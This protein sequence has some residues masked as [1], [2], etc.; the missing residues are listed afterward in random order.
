MNLFYY[1]VSVFGFVL[2][3]IFINYRYLEKGNIESCECDVV[4]FFLSFFFLFVRNS[5]LVL[6]LFI[7]LRFSI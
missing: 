4:D 1:C 5:N 3:C 6:I 7:I 2:G